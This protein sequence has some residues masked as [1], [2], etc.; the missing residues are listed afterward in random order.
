MKKKIRLVS[1]IINVLA[2]IVVS[3]LLIGSTFAW[4]TDSTESYGNK[5]KAGTLKVDLEM[6]NEND[7]WISIKESNAPLFNYTNWEPGYTD[8]KILKIE[9][10]GSL[11]LKWKAMFVTNS[12]LT[13]LANVIDVYVCPSSSE[14][15]FPQD[16][17]LDGYTRVGTAAEFI[18][19]IEQTTYGNLA[20][21]QSAYLGI[22]LVMPT[23]LGNEYQG[24]LMC[25]EFDILIMATQLTLES[26][27]FSDGY[28]ADAT[29]PAPP[30]I[31]VAAGAEGGVEWKLSDEG[32]LTIAPAGASTDPNCGK[33]FPEGTWREAVVYNSKGVGVAI[34]G[35]PYNVN[36]VTSLVIADGVTSIGSF[37]SKFPNLTGEVVIP[38]SVTYIGQEAFQNTKITKLTFAPGGT[39]PLCIAP[40]AFKKLHVEEVIFPADRPEIHIHCWVFA[41]CASLKRVYLTD[42][43]TTFSKWTH[44]EYAGMNYQ[45]GND[46]QIFSECWAL[47]TIVFETEAVKQRFLSAPGNQGNL[48]TIATKNATGSVTLVVE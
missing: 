11:A 31:I 46:S 35:Y 23:S 32:K 37:T 34:G 20:A 3:S 15:S 4:F 30:E 25:G 6:L 2:L 40:G 29:Y 7:E 13:N 33:V 16:N 24:M 12:F 27:G 14:L 38:A 28:D 21:G 47:E 41:G 9:N 10:E 17:N 44:V 8:V 5:I 18:N 36:D 45:N 22:A 39:E 19:T 43:I 26:D 48:N 1:L 42:N